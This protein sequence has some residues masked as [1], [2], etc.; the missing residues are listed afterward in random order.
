MANAVKCPF[1]SRRD[2]CAHLLATIDRY[3][4]TIYSDTISDDLKAFNSQFEEHFRSRLASKDSSDGPSLGYA[5]D[6]LWRE[7]QEN[8]ENDGEFYLMSSGPALLGVMASL[9]EDFGAIDIDEIVDNA[10]PGYNT[11]YVH[12]YAESPSSVSAE[13]RKHLES[14]L[15]K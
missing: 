4:A 15:S 13:I 3:D 12:F 11:V 7:V 9:F 1:C 5:Y 8:Y 14:R 6:A 2:A 10:M